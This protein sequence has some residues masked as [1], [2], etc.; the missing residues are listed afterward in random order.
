MRAGIHRRVEIQRVIARALVV[1]KSQAI[2]MGEEHV[3]QPVAGV[4]AI[5]THMSYVARQP[6]SMRTGFGMNAH[7]MRNE[8]TQAL[9]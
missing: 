3:D 4:A 2:H 5:F 9:R 1:W 7:W 8:C 6:I